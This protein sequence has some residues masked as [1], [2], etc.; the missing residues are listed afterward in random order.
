MP[1]QSMFGSGAPPTPATGNAGASYRS[2]FGFAT[3]QNPTPQQLN[4]IRTRSFYSNPSNIKD[5]PT[6]N[7]ALKY[8]LINQSQW[9]QQ[10]KQIQN[11][12]E[13]NLK[14]V[15]GYT[16]G[17]A[18]NNAKNVAAGIA[19]AAPKAVE[20]T[21]QQIGKQVK[22][23]A[24]PT[25]TQ[26]QRNTITT[27]QNAAA[28]SKEYS[29]AVKGFKPGTN[30]AQGLIQAQKLAAAGAKAPQIKQF[31]AQDAQKLATQTKTGL[32]NAAVLAGINVAGGGLVSKALGAT[33]AAVGKDAAVS[34]L[35]NTAK[36]AKATETAGKA[37]ILGSA[38]V[39]QA[40]TS[41]IPVAGESA[42]VPGKATKVDSA[43]YVKQV[44]QLSK[45]YDKEIAGLKDKPPLTQK[46]MQT[47]ID[48]KYQ[49][50]QQ[51][52]DESA[53]KTNVSFS[54]KTP[55][56]ALST[57]SPKTPLTPVEPAAQPAGKGSIQTA[58]IPAG[59]KVSGSALRTEQKAVEAGMKGEL[60]DK[61]TYNT[62]S[63]KQEAANAVQLLHENPQK[64]EDI[65]MGRTAGNNASHEA[66]VYHAVANDALAQAKR[67]G[68]YSKVTQ[69]AASPR[70]ATVS[71]AAQKLGAE[72]YNVS[73]HD[74]VSIM[75]D[76]AKT[77]E[78]AVTQRVKTTVAKE[79]TKVAQEVKQAMPKVS[80][81]DWHSFIAELQCK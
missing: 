56:P 24:G 1:Y 43:A 69:L 19:L 12:V 50:L 44:N 36:T 58:N 35:I 32:G 57:K 77:R 17:D 75:A 41:K 21:A 45:S 61:A 13:P 67:T 76:V 64:A 2:L 81:Q 6:L 22:Y 73:P 23:L 7:Q 33:K 27:N 14:P 20:S 3:P 68:D 78:K 54:D 4:I 34:D 25:S 28:T 46:V 63:H 49:A 47:Q 15:G 55:S 80:R 10:F 70:H 79:T 18:L 40:K 60:A 16:L 42:T 65:A 74:P 29:A 11:K 71:E 51:K 37:D 30:S 26:A 62:V 5:V 72:G 53:G 66:A 48:R 8:G 52:L 9:Q 38:A 31:L 39:K 59:T